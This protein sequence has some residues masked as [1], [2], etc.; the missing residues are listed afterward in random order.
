MLALTFLSNTITIRIP[1]RCLETTIYQHFYNS[2]CNL[3][4][5]FSYHHLIPKH[6]PP[7]TYPNTMNIWLI[8]TMCIVLKFN[9]T[10]IK[11]SMFSDNLSRLTTHQSKLIYLAD[12]GIIIVNKTKSKAK[13]VLLYEIQNKST[14]NISKTIY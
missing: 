7:L 8:V 12:Y 5:L 6:D 2:L 1:S 11:N 4:L 9:H 3:S 10:K 13:Y 14:T